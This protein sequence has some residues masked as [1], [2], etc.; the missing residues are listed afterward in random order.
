M[1]CVVTVFDGTDTVV[2]NDQV[3]SLDVDYDVLEGGGG[4]LRFLNGDGEVQERWHK[5]SIVV[6]G[7]GKVPQGVRRREPG[8]EGGLDYKQNLTVTIQTALGTDVYTCIS[9]G[10]REGWRTFRGEVTWVLPMEEA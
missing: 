1:P 9:R 5:E 8:G 6:S 10:P 7:T 3:M 4:I 2:M